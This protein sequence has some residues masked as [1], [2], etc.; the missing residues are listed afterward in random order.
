M[1]KSNRTKL[2]QARVT[3]ELHG[4]VKALAEA[5]GVSA[6]TILRWA[7]EEYVERDRRLAPYKEAQGG[8]E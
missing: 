2:L 4:A 6:A 5:R 3:A 1:T 7:M 8:H